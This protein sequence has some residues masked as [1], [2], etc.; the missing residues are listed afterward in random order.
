MAMVTNGSEKKRYLRQTLFYPGKEPVTM[1]VPEDSL[2]VDIHV[3]ANQ[4]R[5]EFGELVDIEIFEWRDD[6]VSATAEAA[7]RAA[8]GRLPV[9]RRNQDVLHD[10]LIATL[11]LVR[12]GGMIAPRS[13]APLTAAQVRGILESVAQHPEYE[14]QNVLVLTSD[15]KAVY[16]TAGHVRVEDVP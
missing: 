15:R 7:R 6:L 5:Q 1:V 16:L 9:E 14:N 11:H 3:A 4:M 10:Y 12:S 13:P 2:K 8:R